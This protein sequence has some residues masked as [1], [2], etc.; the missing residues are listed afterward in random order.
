MHN[1]IFD[2]LEVVRQIHAFF[3]GAWQHVW[4]VITFFGD[5]TFYILAL[6]TIF[7]FSPR[8]ID[9]LC[10]LFIF[11]TGAY[12]NQ[13]L[14]HV[15]MF[16]RP[17]LIDP[18]LTPITRTPGFTF[19]SGHSTGTVV[20]WILLSWHF[21]MERRVRIAAG[22]AIALVP[23]S[24]IVLAQHF[25]QDVLAGVFLGTVIGAGGIFALHALRRIPFASKNAGF[26][27]WIFP[28][29]AVLLSK[30]DAAISLAGT[31]AGLCTAVNL[32]ARP[33]G[34]IYLHIALPAQRK[35]LFF[36]IALIGIIAIKVGLGAVFPKDQVFRFIR[37]FLL[38]LWIVS[39]CLFLEKRTIKKGDPEG[40]PLKT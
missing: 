12:V 17:F 21:N 5:E 37:Y 9:T 36:V 40:P 16:E 20:F 39:S 29:L 26:L 7:F 15:F 33:G 30:G 6:T 27:V 32:F 35:F 25:P 13:H 23:F 31:M 34:P 19:P 1:V 22:F 3:P 18:A 11:L 28:I 24:R 38:A 4:Y 2:G 10:L 14:K 8:R